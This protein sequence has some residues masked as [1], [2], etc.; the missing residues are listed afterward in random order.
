[1][2]DLIKE[3]CMLRYKPTITPIDQKTNLGA[4]TGEPIDQKKY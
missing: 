1:V 3:T 4:E 2:L